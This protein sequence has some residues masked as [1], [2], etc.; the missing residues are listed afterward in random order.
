M[1]SKDGHFP[2]IKAYKLSELYFDLLQFAA[3]FL[4][5]GGRLVYWLPVVKTE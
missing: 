3:K 5:V 4:V 1:S 2:E